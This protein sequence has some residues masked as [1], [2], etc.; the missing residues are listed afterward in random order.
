MGLIRTL[1]ALSVVVSHTSAFFGTSF[2]GGNMAVELFFIISGFYMTMILSEKYVGR[3]SIF[4]FFRG[5]VL[6]LFPLYLLIL[7]LQV[8]FCSIALWTNPDLDSALTYFV[9]NGYELGAGALFFLGI[10]NLILV[11]QE[12]IFF[13]SVSESGNLFFTTK[14]YE[15]TRLLHN[16]MFIPQSWSI[17]I[18]LLFYTVAPFIVNKRF[19]TV[20]IVMIISSCIALILRSN[21]LY[22]D[23]W[24][25]RFLPVVIFYFL[26]GYLSYKL[27]RFTKSQNLSLRLKLVKKRTSL[28]L[29]ILN[30]LIIIFY[31]KL[32]VLV[33]NEIK[34]YMYLTFFTISLPF[35]FDLTKENFWDRFIGEMSYP[36]YLSHMLIVFIVSMFNKNLADT[37]LY[38][39]PLTIIFSVLLNEF[40]LKPIEKIRQT[41]IEVQLKSNN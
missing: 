39:V 41:R 23:P 2:V 40:F 16:Y 3:K 29:L 13:L 37:S 6:R 7:S 9:R 28:V 17:S 1:L 31:Y 4:I 32:P 26:L 27:Y 19:K 33:P 38:I 18:E 5:R 11:G 34:Y 10:E 15:E 14:F 8:L 24:N 22:H 35:I 20:I 21:D 12:I 25:H 30:I 36:I